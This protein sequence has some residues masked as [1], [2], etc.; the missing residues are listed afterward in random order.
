MPTGIRHGTQHGPTC[1]TL[2]S[3]IQSCPWNAHGPKQ[4]SPA[5][6]CWFSVITSGCSPCCAMT[7]RQAKCNPAFW[8]FLRADHI[9]LLHLQRKISSGSQGSKSRVCSAMPFQCLL[10]AKDSALL[11]FGPCELI[12]YGRFIS[13]QPRQHTPCTPPST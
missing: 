3:L 8:Y 5:F 9:H 12:R 11:H 7:V 4:C 6:W 10:W 13:W 2:A 1:R